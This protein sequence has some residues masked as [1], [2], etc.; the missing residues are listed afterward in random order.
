[1]PIALTVADLATG[2]A[3]IVA[4]LATDPSFTATDLALADLATDPTRSYIIKLHVIKTMTPLLKL[5]APCS[6]LTLG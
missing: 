3:A 5:S 6:C 4:D 1:M 2:T